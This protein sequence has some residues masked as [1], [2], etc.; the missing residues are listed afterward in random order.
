MKLGRAD[1]DE[2]GG[3]EIALAGDGRARVP[4]PTRDPKSVSVVRVALTARITD[5]D[6]MARLSYRFALLGSRGR[7]VRWRRFRS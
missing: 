4:V 3:K 7:E 5:I 1:S 2:I 6:T